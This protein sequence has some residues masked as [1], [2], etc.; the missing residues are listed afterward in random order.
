MYLRTMET[1]VSVKTW[2]IF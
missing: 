1:I 2:S